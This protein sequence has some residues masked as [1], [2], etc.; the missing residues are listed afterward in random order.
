MV[1]EEDGSDAV[2]TICVAVDA[3]AAV[4]GVVVTSAAVTEVVMLGVL[5]DV[6]KGVE[7]PELAGENVTKDVLLSEVLAVD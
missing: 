7:E 1:V 2:S 6:S 3:V 4:V 5:F